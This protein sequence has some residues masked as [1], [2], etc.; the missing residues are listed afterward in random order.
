M[1]LLRLPCLLPVYGLIESPAAVCGDG[2]T[3]RADG[4][5]TLS[6]TDHTADSGQRS[7]TGHAVAV[8]VEFP[9]ISWLPLI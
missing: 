2:E 3:I 7:L 6:G 8:T 9:R 5:N 4:F 1:L